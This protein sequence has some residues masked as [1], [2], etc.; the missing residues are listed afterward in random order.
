M[1]GIVVIRTRPEGDNVVKTPGE[2]V[3][4]M[5]V[6]GLEET[7]DDPEVHG[8]DVKVLCNGAPDDRCSDC[9]ETKHHDFD[10][11]SV[12]C[13]QTKWC[14]VLVVNFVDHLV[15][16]TPVETAVRPVVP[17]VFDDEEDGDLVDHLV[18]GRK[19]NVGLKTCVLSERVEEP[20][21]MSAQ[22][23]QSRSLESNIPD[24]WKLDSKVTEQYKFGA[25]PLFSSRRDFLLYLMSA[26]ASLPIV[27]HVTTYILNLVL[28]KVRNAIDNHP[29]QRPTKVDNLVHGKRH[30]ARGEHV[31][32]NVRVPGSPHELEVVELDILLRD[33]LKVVPVSVC[34]VR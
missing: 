29:R 26:T 18:K 11:R 34:S 20:C 8:K 28:V 15:E 4:G 1:M 22:S 31:V 12:F 3:A 16:G 6:D 2:L 17:C 19:G 33:L 25:V 32:A 7:A 14:R 9:A 13:G 27:P 23:L 5:R 30:D 24:L 21:T 10:R